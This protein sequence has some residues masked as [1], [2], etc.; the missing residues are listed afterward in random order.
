MAKRMKRS[1]VKKQMSPVK[2]GLT[3]VNKLKARF[4]YS[5]HVYVLFL[6]ILNKYITGEKSVD[7]VFHEVTT[8]IKD[9]PD[10]VDGFLYSFPIGG[11]V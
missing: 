1:G 8:L 10:L 3:F 9:H 11:G 6:D 4:R 5:P 7:E 2:I